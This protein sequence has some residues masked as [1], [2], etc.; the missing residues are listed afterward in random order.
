MLPRLA[1]I[2]LALTLLAACDTVKEVTYDTLDV[3]NPMN[4]FGDD[5]EEKAEKVKKPIGA[6]AGSQQAK[7]QPYP[8]LQSVPL[9][10]KRPTVE[11]QRKPLAEGLIADTKNARYTDQVLRSEAVFGGK[12]T[13]PGASR[14]PAAPV[15]SPR[16]PPARAAVAPPPK[17]PRV[18]APPAMRAPA[19]PP[20]VRPPAATR[21]Q[22]RP[23]PAPPPPVRAPQRRAV[24][25][26]PPRP[27]G[28]GARQAPPQVAKLPG[29]RSSRF[30]TPTGRPSARATPRPAPAP[31][32]VRPLIEAPGATAPPAAPGIRP[33]P[34][35]SGARARVTKTFQVG[36][37]YF[38]DGSAAITKADVDVL[39][40]VAQVYSQT[41]GTIRVV[42]H[43][44]RNV[45]TLNPAR[46]KA[47][48]FK[49]SLDR[50][51]AVATELIR[52]GVP[53]NRIEVVAQGANQPIY[54]E[55][56][57]TG[58]AANRRAEIFIEYLSE[59]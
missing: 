17:P 8:R 30:A 5:D 46:M 48:N 18:V 19:A 28:L 42:G 56:T 44:S 13:P 39:V 16:Q 57:A 32:P 33:P 21:T 38:R 11:Q 52:Q 9:R 14:Q 20:A 22:I 53:E 37:I 45:R 43:S 29:A 55:S 35:A 59:G 26:P 31:Q 58:E 10:P 1:G 36:T 15:A 34:T 23:P 51:N 3:I 25:P 12:A 7:A 54:A 41:G 50:A 40:T 6:V 47:V 27:K 24:A 49:V 2:G 4:W